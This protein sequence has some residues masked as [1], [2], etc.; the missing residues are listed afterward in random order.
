MEQNDVVIRF[1]GKD[2][3]DFKN[4]EDNLPFSFAKYEKGSL[5]RRRH[6][7]ENDVAV[8]RVQFKKDNV[9]DKIRN[10]LNL[11]NPHKEYLKELSKKCNIILRIY[12]ESNMAQMYLYLPSELMVEM[13]KLSLGLE[14]S[15]FSEGL[16]N[17][18]E[19]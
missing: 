12:L 3:I 13:S 4:L 2:G 7:V 18:I 9:E 14:I 5:I 1:I 15:V 17:S 19:K 8:L 10:L 6:I 16:V 11:L